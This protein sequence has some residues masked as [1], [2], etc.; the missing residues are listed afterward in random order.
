MCCCFQ[1]FKELSA[2]FAARFFD[3]VAKVRAFIISTKFFCY[4]SKIFS[5][6]TCQIHYQ[7]IWRTVAFFEAGCKARKLYLFNQIFLLLSEDFFLRFSTRI[8]EELIAFFKSGRQRYEEYFYQQIFSLFFSH[9]LSTSIHSSSPYLLYRLQRTNP[10]C[11][12]CFDCFFSSS[13]PAVARCLFQIG[14]QR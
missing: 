5:F 4:F 3:R 11:N 1:T 8:F 6:L 12:L 13:T 9:T 14:L 2:F 7:K 10:L